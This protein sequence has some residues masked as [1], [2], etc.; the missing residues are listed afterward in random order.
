[1]RRSP[2]ASC[3]RLKHDF[4]IL[5]KHCPTRTDIKG[6]TFVLSV[7][8]V[9]LHNNKYCNPELRVC[10]ASCASGVASCAL[11]VRSQLREERCAPPTLTS[12]AA[13]QSVSCALALFNTRT[14]VNL[15]E[16]QM[17]ITH[18]AIA[19]GAH[20]VSCLVGEVAHPRNVSCA[21][22]SCELRAQLRPP[23][24]HLFP[25]SESHK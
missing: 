1:M 13:H 5:C 18:L 4:R 19:T 7:Y 12:C 3:S 9:V 10:V 17:S 14:S 21:S 22:A 2:T 8:R 11:Q 25:P 20:V 16:H 23:T 24:S 15:R 6:L